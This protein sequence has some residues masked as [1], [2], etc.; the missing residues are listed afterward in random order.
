[1]ID[2]NLSLPF[3]NNDCAYVYEEK[4]AVKSSSRR[5]KAGKVSAEENL[6][7]TLTLP[8]PANDP[9][10]TQQRKS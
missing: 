10:H 8:F 6:P 9:F 5:V 1:M 7:E 2:Q 4:P 3:L